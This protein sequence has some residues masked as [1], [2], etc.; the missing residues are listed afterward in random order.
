MQGVSVELS[1]SFNGLIPFVYET[2][3]HLIC[4]DASV[5][6]GSLEDDCP[7]DSHTLD[8]PPDIHRRSNSKKKVKQKKKLT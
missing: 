8:E 2:D 1:N 7:S 5:G 3:P 4:L 6:E